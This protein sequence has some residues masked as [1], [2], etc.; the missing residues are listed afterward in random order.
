MEI[1]AFFILLIVLGV[2]V[3]LGGGLYLIGMRLRG[4][5]LHPEGDKLEEERLEREGRSPGTGEGP[6]PQHLEVESEQRTR[7]VGSH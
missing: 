2:V 4:K 3:V 1:G 5:Q 7:F 6:R